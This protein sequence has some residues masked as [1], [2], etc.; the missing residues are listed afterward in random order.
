MLF[1]GDMFNMYEKYAA[2]KGWRFRVVEYN[3]TDI[4]EFICMLYTDPSTIPPLSM[5]LKYKYLETDN[6]RKNWKEKVCH[7][8]AYLMHINEL[9]TLRGRKMS[10]SNRLCISTVFSLNFAFCEV[11][12]S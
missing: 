6:G 10:G 12:N 4:G 1:T 11:P 2:Y 8:W 3:T 9:F 5:D 7:I